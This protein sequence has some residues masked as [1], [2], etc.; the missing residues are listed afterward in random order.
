MTPQQVK[1]W[2]SCRLQRT[3]QVLLFDQVCIFQIFFKYLSSIFQ[4]TCVSEATVA[5]AARES[6]S[7][8]K[9]HLEES[10][11][12][13]NCEHNLV[14]LYP[15]I[16]PA[17]HNPAPLSPQQAALESGLRPSNI[18]PRVMQGA[19]V[20]QPHLP[21]FYAPALTAEHLSAAL[22]D[23]LIA[24]VLCGMTRANLIQV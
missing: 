10:Q 4:V 6:V 20:E 17:V 11:A 23:A 7:I 16:S 13:L 15:T 3:V 2:L 21:Y 9:K 12:V 19:A 14:V 22:Y 8:A 24:L 5:C 1:N 18:S